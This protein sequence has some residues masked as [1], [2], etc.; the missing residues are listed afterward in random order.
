MVYI[1]NYDHQPLLWLVVNASKCQLARTEVFYLGYVLGGGNIKPQ[2]NKVDALRGCPPPTTTT[3]PQK[4][5]GLS[6]TSRGMY[7]SLN[8]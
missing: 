1:M 7:F 8:F 6:N 4:A 3:L 5:I 2:V